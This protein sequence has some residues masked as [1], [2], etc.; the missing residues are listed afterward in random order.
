[1]RVIRWFSALLVLLAASIAIAWTF[2]AVW[3]DAPFGNGNKVAAALLATMFAVVLIFVRPFWRKL[4]VVIV[5]FAGVLTWWLTLSPTNDSDWQ[6]DVAKE[7]WADIQG[8][9]V[10]FHNVRNCDYR[11]ETD[12]TPRW[13]TRT[14]H[15]SQITGID[16]AINYWG[17]PW[18]AHPIVSFHFADHPPLSFSTELRKNFVQNYSSI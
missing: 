16:L 4:V 17:S 15:L 12:Y 1:M 9:E 6:P 10:T 14:V 11:T 18:I 2:G 5:L 3:F 13:E 7:G 8:D